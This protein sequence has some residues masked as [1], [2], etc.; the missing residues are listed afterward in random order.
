[1]SVALDET[2]IPIAAGRIVERFD[3][4]KILLFGSRAR[5]DARQDSEYDLL[6]EGPSGEPR[7]S[8]TAGVSSA[9][10]LE[11]P[12]TH[13]T[14]GRIGLA[15]PLVVD[16]VFDDRRL[17][18][19]TRCKDLYAEASPEEAREA[20]ETAKSLHRRV[21]MLVDLRG[22]VTKPGGAAGG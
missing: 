15:K 11:Y 13:R 19:L 22:P 10:D 4:D 3:P 17:V 9:D 20:F 21:G 7:G 5:G 18:R 16:W 8:R 14:E 12:R 2:P 6:I 1:M